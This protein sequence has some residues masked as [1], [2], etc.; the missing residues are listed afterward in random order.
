M[1]GIGIVA[2]AGP[3]MASPLPLFPF[4]LTPPVESM[5]PMQSAPPVHVAPSENES[6]V[7]EI[8]A[9]LLGWQAGLVIAHA[10][11]GWGDRRSRA[12]RLREVSSD[13]VL[14]AAGMAVMLV[15][16]GLVEAF[17]SQYHEPVL[18][19]GL[20]IAFGSVEAALLT[21]YLARAG[22]QA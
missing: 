8:P 20:K 6:G 11:I 21:L 12:E 1:L 15:W 16:A 7:I 5:P 2:S 3:A 9:I 19:Y 4:I 22:G 18:P 13:V 14:L 10:L 17:I